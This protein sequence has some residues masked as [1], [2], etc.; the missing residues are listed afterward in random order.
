VIAAGI[1]LGVGEL[2]A[3]L[4]AAV[5]SPVAAVGRVVIDVAP[6]S[7]REGGIGAF[8]TADKP[9]L[10]VGTVAVVLVLGGLVGLASRRRSLPAWVAFGGFGALGVIAAATDPM[11]S[12]P[13]AAAVA[14]LA[15]AAGVEALRRLHEEA[16]AAGTAGPL[17]D[18]ERRRFLAVA[19]GGGALALT[20]GSLGRFLAQGGKAA[21]ARARIVLRRPATP[22]PPPPVGLEGATPGLSPLYTPLDRFYR[23][24]TALVVPDVDVASWRLAVGGMVDRPFSLSYDELASLPQVEADITLCCVSNEVGG[25]LIG[26][27]RW[28]GVLLQDLL[29]RAGVQAGASQL[30]GRSVDG[31]TV[32]FPTSVLADGRQALV[33]LGMGGQPLPVRHGFPA[34]LVVPGLYGY[35]SA[36]KWLKE[37]QL[38]TLDAFDAYWVPRGWA[39]EAPIKASARV[40]VPRA[41]QR[42]GAGRQAVAGVAW[43]PS[44]GVGTVEV[45]VDDGPWSP[46]E[47]GPALSADTWRQWVWAW[48]AAPGSHVLRVR[49]VDSAGQE[50]ETEVRPPAPDGSSGL[51]Q[52]RVVVA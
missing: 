18:L 15:A 37:L 14:A 43:A 11:T 26:N 23:I 39:K 31:F 50:Q 12:W 5:P 4:F 13:L 1:A 36:T 47:L 6:R 9:A 35:V 52:I 32:G 29:D 49:T 17:V 38:T 10:L 51:H 25:R 22:L 42:L 16:P 27:A 19:V 40:D 20:T 21:A 28:Q 8:G 34:R 3:A 7:V 30:V 48:D 33:A 2:L 24:D 41:G 44:K 46:A 45:Q